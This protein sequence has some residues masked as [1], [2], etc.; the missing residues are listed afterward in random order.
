[1]RNQHAQSLAERLDGRQ[2][3]ARCRTC[4][5]LLL[6]RIWHHGTG[7]DELPVPVSP[8]MG[9]PH[10]CA[11]HPVHSGIGAEGEIND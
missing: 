1:M 7:W 11:L 2:A 3:F 6:V 9:E 4:P 10:T 8:L 5:A